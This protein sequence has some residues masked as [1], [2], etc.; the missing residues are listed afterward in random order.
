MPATEKAVKC[1]NCGNENLVHNLD[2]AKGDGNVRA[3]G[4]GQPIPYIGHV[5][6]VYLCPSCSSIFPYDK[7]YPANPTLTQIHQQIIEWLNA[8][9]ENKTGVSDAVEQI[10]SIINANKELV[11]LPGLEKDELIS[12]SL[13]PIW[14][15]LDKVWAELKRRRGGRPKG[16]KET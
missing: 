7:H 2:M 4:P 9:S 12:E 1:R 11:G 14:E 5:W 15:E 10:K 16:K 6:K 13:S 8:L 3:G